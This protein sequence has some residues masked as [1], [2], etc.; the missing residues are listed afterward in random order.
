M[1]SE[2]TYNN[3]VHGG[4]IRENSPD[5]MASMKAYA[6]H[7]LALASDLKFIREG[8]NALGRTNSE[9]QVATLMEK[10]ADDRFVLA[11]LGQFKRGKSSLMNAIIGHELL[12]TGV[13]PL[14]SAI[15]VLRYGPD[16]RLIVNYTE[17][18]FPDE[19]PVSALPEFVTESG[20]PGN[21]KKVKTAI[22]E[23]PVPFLRRGVE[24]V[25]TPG[26]GSS[27]EA[28]TATTYGFLPECDAVLFVTSAD[29]P[30]TSAELDFLKEISGYVNKL[31]FVVN[32]IDQID[33]MEQGQILSF[34]SETIQ[35]QTGIRAERIFSVSARLG[36]E[37]RLLGQDDKYRESGIK[38]LEEKLDTFLSGEKQVTFLSAIAHKASFILNREKEQGTFAGP[39][40][41]SYASANQSLRPIS[42]Q[43]D[44]FEAAET[45]LRAWQ[46][47]EQFN[48]SEVCV[49]GLNAIRIENTFSKP[50]G[51]KIKTEPIDIQA[52]LAQRECPV[53]QFIQKMAYQFFSEWQYQLVIDESA[54]REFAGDLGF[55]PLHAWQLL[56]VCSPQGAST[57]FAPLASRVSRLLSNGEFLA[58]F[59]NLEQKEQSCRVCLQNRYVENRYIGE[60]ATYLSGQ[61]GM[62]QYLKSQGVC[63]K[64]LDQLIGRMNDDK[65]QS[66]L[67]KHAAD[68]FEED[69][70]D[71]QTYV[72]K[73]DTLRRAMQ[74]RNEKEAYQ[75]VIARMVGSRGVSTPWPRD[76][77]I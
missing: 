1:D 51:L 53:C 39:Y 40:L 11:V 42:S 57:G 67:I 15:T 61:E 56:A 13:L 5:M 34:V 30:M 12:P 38:A 45:I 43:R 28:N 14:T 26:I 19:L 44:P 54:Q 22:V 25:D 73:R 55:C 59:R 76:G 10:L 74:R 65:T 18:P 35:T 72:L 20:N 21:R 70:D 36:L 31:F 41:K 48:N 77:E 69:A 8:L 46:R 63:L 24:F 27:V 23:L 29:T 50:T 47:I 52:D 32:K 3:T 60:L 62:A 7:K 33:P 49:A 4:K 6:H 64:H 9:K 75:R 71:M 66:L 37:A 58:L 68:R 16:D 2:N 17:S